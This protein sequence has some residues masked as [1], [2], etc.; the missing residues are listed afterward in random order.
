MRFQKKIYWPQPS[1]WRFKAEAIECFNLTS[2]TISRD[3]LRYQ[4]EIYITLGVLEPPIADKTSK[5]FLE[6]TY[7]CCAEAYW[8]NPGV[9]CVFW[10][11][12]LFATSK[13]KIYKMSLWGERR[14]RKKRKAGRENQVDYNVHTLELQLHWY[15]MSGA[16]TSKER[17]GPIDGADFRVLCWLLQLTSTT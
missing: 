17:L 16:R 15:C 1:G 11:A 12:S 8:L 2:E 10:E 3:V 6:P 4:K 14:E 7:L 13:S 5:P 9:P